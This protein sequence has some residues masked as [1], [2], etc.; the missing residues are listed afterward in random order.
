[1]TYLTASLTC[2]IRRFKS[3]IVGSRHVRR[4][5]AEVI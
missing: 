1:M 3:R 2:A 5:L 4:L